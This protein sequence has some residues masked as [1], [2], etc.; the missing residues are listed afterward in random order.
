MLK[1]SIAIKVH[2]LQGR[3]ALFRAR[4]K[5]WIPPHCL[6][7][8]CALGLTPLNSWRGSRLEAE[9]RKKETEERKGGG[10]M[11]SL[12]KSSGFFLNSQYSINPT[13]C[14]NNSPTH[15]LKQSIK[16][17]TRSTITKIRFF[18]F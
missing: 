7:H 11:A 15:A 9:E 12:Y 5:R 3:D 6:T 17:S 2:T 8:P 4:K 10:G 14:A 1:D 18:F 16:R 13:V